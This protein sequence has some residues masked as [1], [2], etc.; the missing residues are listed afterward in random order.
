MNK[1]EDVIVAG[2]EV[3]AADGEQLGTVDRVA[4]KSI[5]IRKG[6]RYTANHAIPQSVIGAVTATRVTLNVTADE[7]LLMGEPQASGSDMRVDAGTPD[8]ALGTDGQHHDPHPVGQSTN[9]PTATK[10]TSADPTTGDSR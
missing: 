4:G 9:G 2:A 3:I 1:R 7:A 6:W 10:V 8:V 5:V